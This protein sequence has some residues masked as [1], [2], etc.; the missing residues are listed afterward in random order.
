MKKHSLFFVPG[1]VLVGT[2]LRIPFTTIPTILTEVADGLGVSVSSLGILTSIPLIMFAT[3]SSLAPKLAEK[4]GLEKLFTMVLLTMV[5][6][7]AMRIFNLPALYL[8][9]MLLGAGIAMMNVLLPSIIQANQPE[10][11]GV[12]TA[13]YTTA[14]GL[15][16]AVAS[17]VAVP[18][19]SATSWKGLILILSAIVF[20]A[21]LI[22]LPNTTFNHYPKKSQKEQN[23]SL[24]KS[25]KAWGLLVF[26][27]LQS[28]MF[29]TALT[30]LP[31]MAT[32]AGLSAEAAGLLASIY[33]LI[34]LPFSV[35]VPYLTEKW[36]GRKRQVA[37]ALVSLSGILGIALLFFQNAS[38]TYWLTVNLLIGVAVSALFPYLLVIYSLKTDT[39]DQTARLSGMVQ[40]GGYLLAAFGPTL[41][42][43]SFEA[44][45]SWN[46]ALIIWL[47]L[48]IVMTA[49][50]FYTEKFDKIID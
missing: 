50:L 7:S 42:G 20:I 44:F 6:G 43:L 29:Y 26:G 2:V 8:G 17:S 41:F 34:S 15:A 47:L 31:T 36:Q 35:V 22:W 25:K 28:L 33:S 40:S 45:G 11:V 39:P 14:M 23:G 30:W 1:I 10:R 38:F 24:W 27:G 12:L 21:F 19:A 46:I 9:T 48:S 32:Q 16:S 5:V 4:F 49:A 18:I 37:L 3:C 13:V